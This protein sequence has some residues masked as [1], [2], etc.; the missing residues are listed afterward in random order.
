MKKSIFTL[1]LSLFLIFLTLEVKAQGDIIV[2]LTMPPPGK[3]NIKDFYAVKLTNNT[4]SEQSVYLVGTATEEKDGL[5]ARGTTVPFKLKTGTTNLQIKDLPKT[6]DIEYLAKDQRYKNSLIRKGEFPAGVYEVCVYVKYSKNKEDAGNDCFTQPIEEE[7][8]LSLINPSDG[9]EIDTKTPV[10]FT[11]IYS[12]QARTFNYTLKITEV[13]KGQT[14]ESAMESNRAFFEEKGINSTTFQYPNSAPKFEKGKSYAWMVKSGNMTS[15][16]WMFDVPAQYQ[17]IVDS[18]TIVCSQ[19]SPS[20]QTCYLTRIYIRNNNP[21]ATGGPSS[22]AKTKVE[23]ITPPPISNPWTSWTN[24]S[25]PNQEILIGTICY[26]NPPP[27]SVAFNIKL[28]DVVNSGF[29]ASLVHTKNLPPCNANCCQYVHYILNSFNITPSNQLNGTYNLTSN[30]SVNGLPNIIAV[31]LEIVY[32]EVAEKDTCYK[33]PTKSS[34]FGNFNSKT[35]PINGLPTIELTTPNSVAP[36][37]YSREITWKTSGAPVPSITNTAINASL[38]FPPSLD[39]DC[40]QD[41]IKI[42]L[43]YSFTDKDCIVCDTLIWRKY[44]RTYSGLQPG[45]H[46]S[47]EL[48]N[49]PLFYEI[50]IEENEVDNNNELHFNYPN[51]NHVKSSIFPLT[52]FNKD[53]E[54]F[55]KYNEVSLQ[56]SIKEEMKLF[57]REELKGTQLSEIEIE[58]RLTEWEKA[59]DES[60]LNK[61]IVF[62][63]TL[64]GPG[65]PCTNGGFELG[66]TT[67]WEGSIS[68]NGGIYTGCLILSPDLWPV[69]PPPTYTNGFV[70]QN[71][72]ATGWSD[73]YFGH[74]QIMPNTNWAPSGNDPILLQCNP[75]ISLSVIPPGGVGGLHSIRIGNPQKGSRVSRIRQTFRNTNNIFEFRYAYVLEESHTCNNGNISGSEA[76]FIARLLDASGAE[77]PGCRLQDIGKYGTIGIEGTNVPSSFNINGRLY[78]SLGVDSVYY[79]T[80]TCVTWNLNNS[81]N[82]TDVTMEYIVAD[83]SGGAH[84]G[85]AYI[86]GACEPCIGGNNNG[87]NTVT[88][89]ANCINPPPATMSICGNYTAPVFNGITATLQSINLQLYHNGT[90]VT[91][92]GPFT[93]VITPPTYCFDLSA[94]DFPGI[95]SGSPSDGFDIVTVANFLMPGGAT[96]SIVS[97]QPTGWYVNPPSQSYPHDFKVFCNPTDCCDDFLTNVSKISLQPGNL[98]NT[99][100]VW[101]LKLNLRAGPQKIKKVRA[102]LEY[103]DTRTPADCQKCNDNEWSAREYGNFILAVPDI[104]SLNGILTDKFNTGWSK[105]SREAVW[106]SDNNSNPIDMYTAPLPTQLL[107]RFPAP[108]LYPANLVDCCPDTITFGIRYRF[109]DTR[110]ITCDTVIYYKVTQKGKTGW[111]VISSNDLEFYDYDKYA[112]IKLNNHEN[113]A[114]EMINIKET[115]IINRCTLANKI[116]L[117][118]DKASDLKIK[119]YDTMGREVLNLFNYNIKEGKYSTDISYYDLPK[120]IYFYKLEKDGIVHYKKLLITT[121]ST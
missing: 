74:H 7:G 20:G 96:S 36:F 79:K 32:F 89:M 97:N 8:I 22:N 10:I 11:W 55:M 98:S 41:T 92:Y 83:C 66:N 115:E 47:G 30:M 40:C 19:S 33:C 64:M 15:E 2:S 112:D 94:S 13:K 103:V 119:L 14:P 86:D 81:Y 90:L 110:C 62:E 87:S 45:G 39:F 35:I 60:R 118:I 117:N 23:L 31:S 42:G 69:I 75:P 17:I 82:N 93:P 91:T 12:G 48:F 84:F 95:T 63:P 18:V 57:I 88:S 1:I 104:G 113:N 38:N 27:T 111:S 53:E 85:Y 116:D 3:L 28:Q 108:L 52:D 24:V 76:F 6:P 70:F 51:E 49:N 56:D 61:N 21:A 54:K 99:G 72:S 101:Q 26:N 68:T 34:M 16:V 106:G 114:N 9:Q 73:A 102:N 80:W 44:V 100:G 25:Y 78:S 105:F 29:N 120:G 107:I 121:K 77:I 4:N 50:P 71:N 58:E 109:T 67:S 37:N 43:R 46:K 5:I 59:Y 65:A